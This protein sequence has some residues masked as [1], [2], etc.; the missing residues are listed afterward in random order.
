M[1]RDLA[2]LSPGG[3]WISFLRGYG[4]VNRV[5]GMYAETIQALAGRYGVPP[6]RFDHPV[7]KQLA[8]A[9]DPS[10]GT[11][12]N[13]VLTGTAGDGKT[14]LCNEVWER[15]GGDSSRTSGANRDDYLVLPVEVGA[16]R[17]RVH[18][19]FEFSGFAP[20][21]GERWPEEKLSLLELFGKS[22][23][24]Q[25]NDDIFVIAANDGKLVQAKEGLVEGSAARHVWR[26]IERMLATGA[27]PGAGR[28]LLFLNLSRMSTRD[29]LSR[30][31]KCLLDREEW[32][33]FDKE[34]DDPAFSSGSPLRLNHSVMAD[35]LFQNR[36]L[37]LAEL[38]D[39]NGL[40][41]SIREI[42]LLLVNALLGDIKSDERVLRLDGLRALAL[43]GRAHEASIYRNL[44]GHN[45][46]DNRREQYAVFRH[47]GTFR[48]GFET[49]NVLDALLVF[50]AEDEDLRQDHQRYVAADDPHGVRTEFERLRRA[51]V[52]AD[53][54]RGEATEFLAALADER[55]RLF[56]RLPD[57]DARLDPWRLTMFQSAASYRRY[58]LGPLSRN[59]E[60]DPAIIRLLVCGLNR[61]WTGMLIG[62]SDM[63][64]VSTGLDTSAAPV[65]DVLVWRIPLIPSDFGERIEIDR[66]PDDMPLLRVSLGIG[67]RSATY[68]LHL[69]R[70]EFLTRV[71]EGALPNS[72][73]KECNEDVLA[74]KSRLL[75]EC[76]AARR[77]TE[78]A[79][80]NRR[81]R[82][83]SLLIQDAE[84]EPRVKMLGVSF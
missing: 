13:V 77:L 65:S 19:I 71:A 58:I 47:L 63:L 34:V 17:I 3:R 59:E 82:P 12:C 55:R 31:L 32:Q 74:F 1:R 70:Y 72:F 10:S 24:G 64:Y 11:L 66:G 83:L 9:L 76:G 33:C 39:A 48:V 56:F 73:S 20:P 43:E 69:L 49:T 41:V 21:R 5:D 60:V 28:N 14:S 15:L 25:A 67:G 84:G 46:K 38:C 7:A 18:F 37:A 40:H 6:L 36:L 44:F 54:D 42:L 62:E 78:S 75:S 23:L 52:D 50:G 51:Y 22:V 57:R 8:E 61:I 30:A 16:R 2:S 35:S 45:L 80:P 27:E 81:G 53:E 79:S 4:P 26:D 68:P 29:L